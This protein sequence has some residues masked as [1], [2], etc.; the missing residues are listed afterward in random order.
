MEPKGKKML[1]GLGIFFLIWGV[2]IVGIG[3]IVKS[4]SGMV[5]SQSEMQQ[6]ALTMQ[7]G[8]GGQVLENFLKMMGYALMINGICFFVVGIFGIAFCKILH[9]GRVLAFFGIVLIIVCAVNLGLSLPVGYV[10]AIGHIV[11]ICFGLLFLIGAERNVHSLSA[12]KALSNAAKI[13]ALSEKSEK[14]ETEE[15]AEPIQLEMETEEKAGE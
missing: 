11:N 4:A 5:T 2:L 13:E 10:M 15:K 9:M 7:M 3:F 8:M 1:K 12:G 6:M 14:I